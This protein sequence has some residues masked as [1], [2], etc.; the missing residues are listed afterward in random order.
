MAASNLKQEITD[1]RRSRRAD[2][3]VNALIEAGPGRTYETSARNVSAHGV[4]VEL[5]MEL[6]PGRPVHIALA[7]LG[8]VAGRIAWARDGHTGIAFVDPLTLAQ[9]NDIL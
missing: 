1:D 7:G 6:A 9:I 8:R 4:M 5:E 2:V 3:R